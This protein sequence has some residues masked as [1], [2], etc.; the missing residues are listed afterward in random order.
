MNR[1]NELVK[2]GNVLEVLEQLKTLGVSNRKICSLS[3]VKISTLCRYK[4]GE[5]ILGDD[6]QQ[7]ILDTV[8]KVY[9]SDKN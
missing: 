2:E 9:L 7:M 6:K 4:Q 3:G 1:L 5:F 8:K